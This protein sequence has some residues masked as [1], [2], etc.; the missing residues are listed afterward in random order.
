MKIPGSVLLISGGC[1][2]L[3]LAAVEYFAAEGAKILYLDI[4][5][6]DA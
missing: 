1:S 4:K 5:E 6:P 3:G 2:G